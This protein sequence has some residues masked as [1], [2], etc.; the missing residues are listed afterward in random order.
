MS[1]TLVLGTDFTEAMRYGQWLLRSHTEVTT[2]DGGLVGTHLASA[3]LSARRPVLL[4]GLRP[5][6]DAHVEEL[7]VARRHLPYDVVTIGHD[8]S[9]LVPQTTHDAGYSVH[10]ASRLLAARLSATSDLLHLLIAGRVVDLT[11]MPMVPAG[12]QHCQT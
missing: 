7:E 1:T 4:H 3:L 2:I 10:D 11:D 5:W 9:W 6:V 8:L 12:S